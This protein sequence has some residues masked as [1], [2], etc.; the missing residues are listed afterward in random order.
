MKSIHW[1]TLLLTAAAGAVCLLGCGGKAGAPKAGVSKTEVSKAGKSKA[2]VRHGAVLTVSNAQ[3]F[4]AA[5]G[6]NRVIEL[7]PG[8]YN[9]SDWDSGD[10]DS[11][12]GLSDLPEGVAWSEENGEGLTLTGIKHLTIRVATDVNDDGN[13]AKLIVDPRNV[14]VLRFVNCSDIV[15]EG[16]TAGHSE[17]GMCGGGVLKFEESSR[18]T[19]NGASLYG[20]GTEGFHLKNVSDMKVTNT[21]I[22][23]CTERIF[24][25]SGG[26]KVVFENCTFD[27]NVGYHLVYVAGDGD[28]HLSI[29]GCEF[30]NNRNEDA[31]GGMFFLTGEGISIS[32][33]KFI[34]NKINRISVGNNSVLFD[35]DCEFDDAFIDARDGTAYKFVKIGNQTWMA[36]N[37]NYRTDN[38]YCYNNSDYAC[39]GY[40][41]LYRWDAAKKA[42]PAGW[43]L[44]SKEEWDGLI[45][46]TGGNAAGK[47][48]KSVSGW[49]GDG[50][51][52]DEYGFSALPAGAR[53]TEGGSVGAGNFG[54]WWTATENGSDNAYDWF[55]FHDKD[56][57]NMGIDHK[58]NGFYVRCVYNAASEFAAAPAAVSKTV[59][60][61]SALA[62]ARDVMKYKTVK[63]GGQTWMAENLNITPPD[64]NS[65]CYENKTKNCDKYGRL[66]DLSTAEKVCPK[67]YRLP[68]REDWE[69][70]AG[71]A[72]LKKKPDNGGYNGTVWT[73]A[74]KLKAKSGWKMYNEGV[75]SNVTDAL[76]FSA[77]PGGSRCAQGHIEE[78]YCNEWTGEI[79]VLGK[80]WSSGIGDDGEAS[81]FEIEE[82]EA[83]LVTEMSRAGSG[84]GYS[85]RCVAD[86]EPE[87]ED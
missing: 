47:A 28:Q 50:N 7:M 12:G 67:G 61:K 55:M 32:R 26:G 74:R 84:F 80:W 53:N 27:H 52:T 40:G 4:R 13:P 5:L 18:I 51:G 42:C 35:P 75:V 15:I 2:A 24:S 41:R 29:T 49:N 21:R 81:N 79:G 23:E 59:A 60:T 63:I 14:Y 62:A 78:G 10:A 16:I 31:S 65:W 56:I 44:P 69:T 57:A 72:G 39:V 22:Y 46:A 48:L 9:I 77:L 66:Y 8:V 76:G 34:G 70:F 58:N 86:A 71:S 82:N 87:N 45:A 68:T 3:E 17:G 1:R 38:S 33:T 83:R 43:H 20:S 64:G 37:M 30:R 25:V 54:S 19:V 6:S 73:G 85:V 36:D 11:E